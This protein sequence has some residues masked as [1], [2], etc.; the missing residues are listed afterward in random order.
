MQTNISPIEQAKKHFA[1]RHV[2]LPIFLIVLT[3]FMAP[4][5]TFSAA[6]SK[7]PPE[8]LR[9]ANSQPETTVR[10]IAQAAASTD[11][12][13]S[14][15]EAYDGDVLGDLTIIN[16]Y[17]AEMK[18]G[19]AL[20]LAQTDEVRWVSLDAAIEQSATNTYFAL[21]KFDT[22]AYDNNDGNVDWS[23]SWLELGEEN[24]PKGGNVKIAR[25]N[26]YLL[27]RTAG[28][29][30]IERQLPDFTG[31]V[32]ATLSFDYM[33]SK[34]DNADDYV[35][36]QIRVNNTTDWQELTRIAGP[37]NNKSYKGLTLDITEFAGPNTTIRLISSPTLGRK[38]EI[39]FDNIKIEWAFENNQVDPIDPADLANIFQETVN[40]R[41]V[42]DLGINGEGVGIAIIDSG[43]TED[44]DFLAENGSQRVQRHSFMINLPTNDTYG[45]GTHVAGIAA[46]NL[47]GIAPGADI[48]SLRVSDANG[49]AYE[50]NVVLALQWVLENKDAYNIRVTNLSINSTVEQS[51]HTSPMDAAAEIL[52]FNGVVVVTSSGNKGPG[53]GH[54]TADSSPANDPFFITVGA[55]REHG[56]ANR[57]N[58]S[59]APFSAHG[60]TMDGFDK[61]EIIAPG[62]N[63]VS[64]LADTSNWGTEY[65]DRS[66]LN[67]QYFRLSGTSMS[68][69]MVT[70]AVALLLQNEPDLTPDQVKYRLL[71]SGS[72]IEGELEDDA[73]TFAYLDVFAVITNNTTESA[74]T[75]IEASQLLWTGSGPVAW[76][77]VN[78][79]SVNWGSVNW[80]SVNWGSVNWG[81]VNWGSVNWDD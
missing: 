4:G 72:S 79:G 41:P 26:K 32:D 69:P 61:P 16:A 20:A 30:G 42:W 7:A 75:G 78:W 23:D 54:N 64:V 80:G 53:G 67:G 71:H 31:A 55:S 50:S 49:M 60:T 6:S 5:A 17:V 40:V 46:G 57:Q 43:V 37:K 22:R 28:N 76:D 25:R 33:R 2:L 19:A 27:I 14:A 73:H 58:H 21:D 9:L 12:A 51:Y 1:F 81:S 47:T 59:I 77:S 44:D 70:G 66:Q 24:G 13:K 48:Y 3:F 68:A 63:I 8:L 10:I 36:I 56:T 62:E 38:D 39:R 45:H 29:I 18:A 65:P 74:N 15:I 52:W 35:S 34:L 11:A